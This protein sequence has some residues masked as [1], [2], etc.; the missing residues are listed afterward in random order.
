MLVGI[1]LATILAPFGGWQGALLGMALGMSLEIPI[2]LRTLCVRLLTGKRNV[3]DEDSDRPARDSLGTSPGESPPSEAVIHIAPSRKKGFSYR[4]FAQRCAILSGAISL[5]LN[6]ILAFAV[7]GLLYLAVGV[8]VALATGPLM[9][10]VLWLF[11]R[12][13]EEELATKGYRW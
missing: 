8:V 12:L 7:M 6:L 2:A 4:A 10:L 13:F 1:V 11:W 5:V 9:Y 3:R